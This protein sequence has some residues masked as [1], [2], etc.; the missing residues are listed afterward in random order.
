M[1]NVKAN[2]ILSVYI[3]REH[4]STHAPIS[5]ILKCRLQKIY[6]MAHGAWIKQTNICYYNLIAFPAACALGGSKV[7]H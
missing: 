4:K 3:I 6:I 1:N 5:S 7:M 2:K